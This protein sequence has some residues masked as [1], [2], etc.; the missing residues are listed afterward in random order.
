[1]LSVNSVVVSFYDDDDEKPIQCE[2]CS[3]YMHEYVVRCLYVCSVAQ[4]ASLLVF[5]CTT[6]VLAK[7]LRM[8]LM[9]TLVAGL[10]MSAIGI[11]VSL[12][13]VVTVFPDAPPPPLLLRLPFPQCSYIL[14][15]ANL[16]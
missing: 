8:Y 10:L 1:M 14:G 4:P 11:L 9:S 16:G 13:V 12:I 5:G 2:V 7:G 15:Q 3:P 6:H